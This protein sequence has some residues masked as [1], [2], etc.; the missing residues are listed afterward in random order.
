MT[1]DEMLTLAIP[2]DLA[3][4]DAE[5]CRQRLLGLLA[6]GDAPVTVLFE[7]EERLGVVAM[8]LAL[9]ATTA[10]N[11]AGRAASFDADSRAALAHLGW[12]G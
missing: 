2:A 9:A 6:A 12:E 3:V 11:A 7:G 10:A 5:E 8:Q 4:A 1:D